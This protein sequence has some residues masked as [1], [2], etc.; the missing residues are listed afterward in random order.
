MILTPPCTLIFM[1]DCV[2]LYIIYKV[3]SE[4]FNVYAYSQG[5]TSA[6]AYHLHA[7]GAGSA[8]RSMY[9][10]K[11]SVASAGH[12]S[13][14]IWEATTMQ[15]YAAFAADAEVAKSLKAANMP[16]AREMQNVLL[17]HLLHTSTIFEFTIFKIL[18]YTQR[19]ARSRH[20]SY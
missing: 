16:A 8:T 7:Q 15:E 5:G 1:S 12:Y 17:T 13:T 11:Q 3:A 4:W 6:L 20:W 10:L 14:A 18:S 2:T 9:E 19:F